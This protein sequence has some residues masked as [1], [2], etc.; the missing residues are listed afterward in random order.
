MNKTIM[1]INYGE[2]LGN[3][4]GKKTVDDVCR[5]AA[6]IGY[7]GIEFRGEP[8]VEMAGLSF[9]EYCEEIAAAKKKY[10]LS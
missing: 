6:Q 9:R 4:F 3:H 7:D 1:H 5:M 10:S 8:P 2:V